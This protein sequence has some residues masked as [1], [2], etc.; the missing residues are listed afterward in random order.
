MN[1]IKQ[2]MPQGKQTIL[3]YLLNLRFLRFLTSLHFK[4]ST[5]SSTKKSIKSFWAMHNLP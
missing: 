3:A 4:K 5:K 2:L 1:T